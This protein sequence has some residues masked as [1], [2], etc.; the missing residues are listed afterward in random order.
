MFINLSNHPTALW[1]TEQMAEAKNFGEVLD[2]PFPNITPE[3]TTEE[4]QRMADDFANRITERR[5]NESLVV[6]IMGEMTFTFK[7]VERLKSL[8][9]RCV[10]STTERRAYDDD[11]GKKV[12]EFKFVQFRDY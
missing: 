11:K 9:I 4:V 5:G 8:G 3:S 2:M 12:S 10:A 6:H 1:T 7:V